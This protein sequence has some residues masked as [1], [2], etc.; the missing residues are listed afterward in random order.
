MCPAQTH[1]QETEILELDATARRAEREWTVSVPKLGTSA[2]ATKL[3]DA[4]REARR[5]AADRLGVSASGL[6][7]KFHLLDAAAT[8]PNQ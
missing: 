3:S 7:L 4:E 2:R 5:L 8:E 6:T 1:Q